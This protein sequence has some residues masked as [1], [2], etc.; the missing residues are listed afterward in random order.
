MTP[1][2]EQIKQHYSQAVKRS[3]D[4]YAGLQEKEWKKK[5]SGDWTAKDTLAH[6][7][8]T[9]EEEANRLVEQA[10]A[11]EAGQL[12]GFD[13]RKGINDYN[14][15]KLATV[16][17]LPVSELM[18]RF[19]AA[20][21]ESL[22]T[23]DGL[24]E[25]DLDKP[26]SSPGWDSPGTVRDLF[27]ASYLHLPGHYQGIRRVAKKKLPHWMDAGDPEDVKFHLG[28]IFHYMPLIFWPERATDMQATFLFTMEGESGG[29]WAVRI[30][31]GQA[32][33]QDGQPESFDMELRTK[34]E[35]WIDLSTGDLNAMWAITTRKVHI[36]G[37][38]ALAMK[39]DQLFQVN[40]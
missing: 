23:L 9:Q 17:D 1:S 29:Q 16:R 25:A 3:L 38:A 5:A 4:A 34:P 11:G 36:G 31:D 33:T 8:V 26:A 12:T 24:S 35:L 40:E 37:N 18:D 20:F 27:F 2:K 14:E 7:V 13:D 28:R 39:L 22:R 10:L 15:Q 19:K 6:L 21:E 30:D 32:E